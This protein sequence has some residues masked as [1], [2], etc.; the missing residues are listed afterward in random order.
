MVLHDDFLVVV[1]VGKL[2]SKELTVYHQLPN[3]FNRGFSKIPPDATSIFEGLHRPCAKG[4]PMARYPNKS[5]FIGLF[6]IPSGSIWRNSV[7]TSLSAANSSYSGP[8]F[9]CGD[10]NQVLSPVDK[11]EKNSHHTPGSLSF[12][13]FLA[14]FGLIEVKNVGHWFTWTN[15]REGDACTFERLDKGWCN[16][17]WLDL[18]PK[19]Y[20][21]NLGISRSDHA[22]IS[23][24][25][26]PPSTL[27][28][29]PSK[30]EAWWLQNTTATQII[31]FTWNLP[32]PGSPLFKVVNHNKSMLKVLK[33]WAR[34]RKDSI[35]VKI[36][37]IQSQLCSVLE[38]ISSSNLLLEKSL[39]KDLDSLLEQK[40]LFWAQRA[41]QHWRT[42]GDSNTKF[43]HSMTKARRAR[44][45]VWQLNSSSGHVLKD[46][47]DIRVE[48]HQHFKSFYSSAS[49]SS[50]ETLQSLIPF[51]TLSEDQLV[52]LNLPFQAW[53][54][55]KLFSKW[56]P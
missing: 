29:F 9:L 32:L 44:N 54:V 19:A 30:F 26:S 10:F 27:F 56:L 55:K 7:W 24:V 31:K 37:M 13:S 2:L 17:G 36:K 6:T 39:R 45:H 28:P 43:F 34:E 49:P 12:H 21:S 53:E 52:V 50:L 15:N 8:L 5:L 22:P 23:F 3:D 4:H 33:L 38:N 11:W 16:L 18:F 48:F 47:S 35:P 51:S 20:M 1:V 40:E 41:K 14:F 42:L 25:T 46:E